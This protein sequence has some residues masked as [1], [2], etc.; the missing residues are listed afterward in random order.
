MAFFIPFRP[1]S[2][3]HIEEWLSEGE[4]LIIPRGVEHLPVA[5][6]EVWIMLV[7]PA[8]TLNTGNVVSAKTVAEPEHI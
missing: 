7:E 4:L 3:P 6:E 5:A 8:G 2:L 1:A